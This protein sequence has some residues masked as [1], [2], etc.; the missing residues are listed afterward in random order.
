MRKNYAL[1]TLE[2]AYIPYFG[3]KDEERDLAMDAFY[4]MDETAREQSA[5][6]LP[7]DGELDDDGVFHLPALYSA[8]RAPYGMLG[9]SIRA[10][11]RHSVVEIARRYGSDY[12]V[13]VAL[14]KALEMPCI[15]HV[16]AVLDLAQRRTDEQST[17]RAKTER[18]KKLISDI[19][20]A[21]LYPNADLGCRVSDPSGLDGALK[22]FCFVCQVYCCDVHRQVRLLPRHPIPDPSL[23]QRKAA[24][25]SATKPTSKSGVLEPCSRSCHLLPRWKQSPF[26]VNENLP[27]TVQERGIFLEALALFHQDPCR[28]CVVIGSRKCREVRRKLRDNVDALWLKRA[29]DTVAQHRSVLKENR[30]IAS[31]RTG[32]SN[33]GTSESGSDTDEEPLIGKDRKIVDKRAPGR[34]KKSKGLRQRQAISAARKTLHAAAGSAREQGEDETAGSI[35]FIPCDHD[36]ACHLNK[37]CTCYANS[38]ICQTSCGCNALRYCQEGSRIVRKGEDCS[39][40]QAGCD[41]VDGCCNDSSCQ[42]F[43]TNKAACL[44]DECACDCRIPPWE[45]SVRDRKCKSADIIIRRHKKTFV[46]KSEI[47]GYGLFAGDYFDEGDLVGEYVGGQWNFDMVDSVLAVGEVKERTYAYDV[48]NVTIDGTMFGAKIKFVNHSVTKK[49]ENCRPEAVCVKGHWHLRLIASR[50][51]HPGTEFLFNYGLNGKNDFEWLR[52]AEEKNALEAPGT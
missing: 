39:L 29:T 17:N 41:C 37:D 14:R 13:L 35:S 34:K 24:A 51:V 28:I 6:D 11:Q 42:C 27:W 32:R 49:G 45:I 22:H 7:S 47:E 10:A 8:M 20:K 40:T 3:D 1:D 12:F 9:K 44:P 33:S 48:Q 16:R 4:K 23:Q 43:A 30:R 31:L 19:Q 2:E 46:G 36:G 52:K 50:S 18:S 5:F 26:D 38:R 25:R 15:R 21:I